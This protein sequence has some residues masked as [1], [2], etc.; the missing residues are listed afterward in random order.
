MTSP[1][2][3]AL[4]TTAAT[5]PNRLLHPPTHL[6]GDADEDTGDIAQARYWT[7]RAMEWAYE[8]DDERML[9]WTIFRRSQ[10]AAA[11]S[12]AAQVIALAEAAR[13]KEEQLATPSRAAI[14]V[15]EAYG[16]ALDGDEQAGSAK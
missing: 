14:G 1:D 15:Q 13:W 5:R 10:Q 8:G 2:V 3:A 6:L 12:D 11:T 7:S 9:A 16:H 4:P